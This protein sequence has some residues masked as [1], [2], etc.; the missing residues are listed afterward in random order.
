MSE[1]IVKIPEI[2]PQKG[3]T[4]RTII[5]KTKI[6]EIHLWR[7]A[8]EGWVYPHI[9]PNNDDIWYILEGE[10]E[11]YFNSKE[12][13][14]V[15]PGDIAVA[16]PGDVHGV[17]NFGSEDIIIYSVLSPLPVEI[18]PAPDFEYPK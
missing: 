6:H 9:H 12:I 8:P 1:R 5:F 11:Y 4:S 17:F 7:V 18:E 14:T 3:S 13:I 10:G 16:A 2:L 15:R